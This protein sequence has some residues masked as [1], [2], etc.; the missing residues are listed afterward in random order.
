MT[1]YTQH[2]NTNSGP[3][4]LRITDMRFVD[5]VG[6]P[7]DCTILRIDTNQG[8]S[9]YGEVRDFSNKFYAL[10][11]KRIL[12]GENPCNVNKIFAKI[13]QFG[14]HARQGGGVSGVEVALWD[15]AGK[16]FGV[17][18]YQMLGGKTRDKVRVYCDTDVS[19]KHSGADMGR[20]L[21]ARMDNGF[22]MLKMDLGM[23]LLVDVKGALNAPL[24]YVD[25]LRA[26]DQEELSFGISNKSFAD[27]MS[28]K[29]PFTGM[30]ITEIGLDY[31]EDYVKQA[32][33][34]IGYEVPLA[35]DH[36]GH[37][38]YQSCLRLAKRLEKYN[39]FWMEDCI[40]WQYT[41]QWKTLSESTTVPM[42]TGEDIFGKEAFRP[43]IESRAVSIIHPDIL[44][45]GGISETMKI[46]DMAYDNGIAAAIHM[47]ESPIGCMAAASVCAAAGDNVIA[48]EFHSHDVG[49]WDSIVK[50]S[51]K[52]IIQNGFITL[53]DKPGLGIEELDDE[54]L[55]EH[56]NPKRPGLWETTDSWD[57]EWAHDRN[58]S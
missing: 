14:S 26:F 37:V 41:E 12:I 21:K 55:A 52:N 30:S 32:R 58:W 48:M 49:W 4:E 46:L 15:I 31:L 51:T 28:V 5:I 54:V 19:G 33:D 10:Q 42:C 40:P 8:I 29:H 34:A 43:L 2:I 44:T 45:A 7:M 50:G 16:A 57:K 36:I 6:A 35:V 23:D 9:G 27:F 18:V 56:I 24:G 17:P 22:T 1:D 20:A 38:N 3:S 13:K 47:A 39:I 11:L 53:T 25:Q